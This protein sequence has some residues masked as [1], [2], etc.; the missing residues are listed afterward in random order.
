MLNYGCD[1]KCVFYQMC[2]WLDGE[3][4]NVIVCF[5]SFNYFFVWRNVLIGLRRIGSCWVVDVRNSK[6]DLISHV[7]VGIFNFETWVLKVKRCQTCKYWSGL[8]LMKF[9]FLAWRHL[10]LIFTLHYRIRMRTAC[11]SL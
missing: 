2:G 1:E 3:F 11:Y 10:S 5:Y 4:F 7:F 8:K 6:L 9:D